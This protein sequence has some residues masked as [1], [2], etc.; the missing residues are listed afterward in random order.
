MRKFKKSNAKGFTLIEL[1][2]VIAIIGVLAAVLIPSML[3]FIRDA[4]VSNANSAAK[5]V[6]TGA[7]SWLTQSIT[8]N[9]VDPNEFIGS[10][11]AQN[12][13][14]STGALPAGTIPGSTPANYAVNL[15]KYLGASYD[16]GNWKFVIDDVQGET[17][18]FALWQANAAPVIWPDAVW[19][20]VTTNPIVGSYPSNNGTTAQFDGANIIVNVAV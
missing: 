16:D 4:R 6:H 15:E 8:Q 5:L 1:I 9:V 7:Q 20:D 11:W 10:T 17:I 18:L 14:T 19:L 2:V 3:G 12:T 13:A